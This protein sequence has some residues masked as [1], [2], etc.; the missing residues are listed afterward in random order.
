MPIRL[1]LEGEKILESPFTIFKS[2]VSEEDFWNFASEDIKCEL[3]DGVL[4]IHS[5]ANQEHED[6]FSLLL[7]LFR[8]YL[9]NT[10]IGKVFGSRFVMH[11]SEKWNP[12]P[13]LLV[14]LND[15]L[16]NLE[17]G[18]LQ[19]PADLVVEILSESTR[20]TDIEDKIPHFL[21]E[22][23]QEAWIIDPEN[24]AIT[25]RWNDGEM[26]YQDPDSAE[27]IASRILPGLRIP[28]AWIWNRA[29]HPTKED[30][31]ELIG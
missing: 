10:G 5:P 21:N 13:D 20:K 8:Y 15:K 27:V 4:I 16:D 19:G 29:S 28:V 30:L 25:L 17:S 18:K 26:I 22:G 9:V 6:I 2:N 14:I 11:L 3:I 23:V 31:Q 24:K 1:I 12:E 7:T